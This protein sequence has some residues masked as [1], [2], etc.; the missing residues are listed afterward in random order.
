LIHG[1]QLMSGS[2]AL[3]FDQKR[4]GV[5]DRSAHGHEF[6]TRSLLHEHVGA[7]TDI[8]GAGKLLM[9]SMVTGRSLLPM[10]K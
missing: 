2:V 5:S 7:A 8:C 6:G 9:A 1:S 3:A 4:V 10:E